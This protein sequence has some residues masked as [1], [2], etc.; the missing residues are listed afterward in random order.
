MRA[1]IAVLRQQQPRS[2]IVA[3]PVG[4]IEICHELQQEVDKVICLITP[5]PLQAIGLWY[6]NFSQTTDAEVRSLLATQY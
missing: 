3:V 6:G 5:R 1:A 4:A 2:I